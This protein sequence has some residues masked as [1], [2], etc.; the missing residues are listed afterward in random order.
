VQILNVATGKT[1][2][3]PLPA[4]PQP[5]SSHLTAVWGLGSFSDNGQLLLYETFGGTVD[6]VSANAGV[7]LLGI[8]T[9]GAG[10]QS[11]AGWL[12]GGPVLMV[13]AGRRFGR[14]GKP[15]PLPRLASG[16]RVI[17]P[18]GLQP[19][20]TRQRSACSVSGLTPCAGTDTARSI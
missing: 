2:S 19:S 12:D 5:H 14:R 3:T 8:P 18:S 15:R 7:L 11:A 10:E 1:V 4:G 6:I 13:A 20:R 16:S 17:P 9:V